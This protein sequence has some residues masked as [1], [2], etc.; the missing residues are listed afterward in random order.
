MHE[1]NA[2]TKSFHFMHS[3]CMSVVIFM[4]YCQLYWLEIVIQGSQRFI[5]SIQKVN[6]IYL[7]VHV[8][9]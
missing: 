3:F 6:D 7:L 1:Y 4:H 9:L 8:N 5:G 2:S